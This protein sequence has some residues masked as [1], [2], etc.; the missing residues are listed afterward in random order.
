VFYQKLRKIDFSQTMGTLWYH[1]R[2]MP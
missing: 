2:L 1:L